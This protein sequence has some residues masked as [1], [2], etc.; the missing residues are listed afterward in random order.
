MQKIFIA[1]FFGP[2]SDR[3]KISGTP[4]FWS[5]CL[6]FIFADCGS[7]GPLGMEDR[8]IDDTQITASS[9]YSDYKPHLA[10]LNNQGSNYWA[11]VTDYSNPRSSWIQVDFLTNVELYG[12]KIQGFRDSLDQYMHVSQ[13][14]VQTGDSE[15]SLKFIEDESG[16]PK[17]K[18]LINPLILID[19]T[20]LPR[21]CVLTL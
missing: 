13:L 8:S 12:I 3:K 6:I 1:K 10:R 11:W 16:N 17:V 21:W 20:A 9:Y 19:R 7:F 4:L 2:P 14:E 15:E 18:V 5:I